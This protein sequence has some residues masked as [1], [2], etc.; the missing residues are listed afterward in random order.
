MDLWDRIG[1]AADEVPVSDEILA[2]LDRRIE[3]DDRN[4]ELSVTWEELK[5][6][7]WGPNL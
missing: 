7:I 4:P 5:L 2:E 3:E 6:R 1:A